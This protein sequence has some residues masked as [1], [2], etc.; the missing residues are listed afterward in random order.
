MGLLLVEERRLFGRSFPTFNLGSYKRY[1]GK[2][3]S[4]VVLNLKTERLKKDL[5]ENSTI[6]RKNDLFYV[7]SYINPHTYA[8]L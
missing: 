4:K 7:Y 1:Y 3:K 6:L 2:V 5:G 8:P